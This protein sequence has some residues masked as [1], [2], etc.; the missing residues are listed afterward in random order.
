[1]IKIKTKCDCQ[2]IQVW[3][4]KLKTKN[5]EMWPVEI[6]QITFLT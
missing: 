6:N 5:N 3:D 4:N 1:M 2:S